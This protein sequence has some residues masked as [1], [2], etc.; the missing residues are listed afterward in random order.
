ME[1]GKER[2]RGNTQDG[3][4]G[5]NLQRG[6]RGG[7]EGDRESARG[8]GREAGRQGGRQAGRQG[9]TDEGRASEGYRHPVLQRWDSFQAWDLVQLWQRRAKE[10]D[11]KPSRL[12]TNHL[13]EE[14]AYIGQ[15]ATLRF[16]SAGMGRGGPLTGFGKTMYLLSL[17]FSLK[18]SRFSASYRISTCS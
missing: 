8:A 9:G 15:P 16:H 3:G 1:G 12:F 13:R 17:K 4:R 5:R 14:C 11:T 18:A 10:S 6:H 7:G 2:G